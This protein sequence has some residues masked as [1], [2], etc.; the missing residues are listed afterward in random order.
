MVKLRLSVDLGESSQGF[1]KCLEGV[2][3]G[4]FSQIKKRGSNVLAMMKVL[5]RERAIFKVFNQFLI[6]QLLSAM[7]AG[8]IS[9]RDVRSR[10]FVTI[11]RLPLS[12]DGWRLSPTP[13]R[14]TF[15]TL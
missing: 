5:I 1:G 12:G 6:S 13:D 14:R 10:V 4:V 3:H 7:T 8:V 11:A 15:S 2:K 9:V